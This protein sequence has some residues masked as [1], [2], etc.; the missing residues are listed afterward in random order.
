MPL[1]PHL[2]GDYL[3][4]PGISPYSCGVVSAPGFE[5]AHVTFPHLI[6][7]RR[8]FDVIENYLKDSRRP[9]AALCGIELRSP[10]PFTFSGFAEFNAGYSKILEDWGLFVDGI[11]PVART[12]VAPEVDPPSEPGLF[13]FSFTR[14]C[15]PFLPPVLPPTFVVSGAG[16][17]PE[18]VLAHE[19]IIR[20]G[21]TSAEAMIEKA[22]FVMELMETRLH[23]LGAYWSEVTAVNIY[24]VHALE[25]ILPE[26]ILKRIGSAGALGVHWF[27][28]RPPIVGIEFE[29]D[30]RGCFEQ[31]SSDTD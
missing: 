11:N 27:F 29:M 2:Q 17:L 16:E 10:S 26:V 24:T 23:G 31:D 1:I 4:L 3:F 8:I 14:E 5:I 6:A 15:D 22:S 13:G 9:K 12:N 25:R 30:L 20:V 21:D 18:G 7:Y 28:S 19:A